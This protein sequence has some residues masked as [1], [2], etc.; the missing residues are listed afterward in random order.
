MKSK[1][2]IGIIAATLTYASLYYFIG[3]KECCHSNKLGSQ[4]TNSIGGIKK[5]NL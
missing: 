3:K 4:Q 1:L 5:S 2:L